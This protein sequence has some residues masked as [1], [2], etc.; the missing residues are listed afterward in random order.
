MLVDEPQ[1]ETIEGCHP[2]EP[3]S[4]NFA[5]LREKFHSARHPIATEDPLV[6]VCRGRGRA[7]QGERQRGR[8]VGANTLKVQLQ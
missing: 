3:T 1:V 5:P 2:H 7:A 6:S 4:H 8:G